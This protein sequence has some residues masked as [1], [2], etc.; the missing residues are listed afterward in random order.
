MAPDPD[1]ATHRGTGQEAYGVGSLRH[2]VL[3]SPSG[4]L[5][6]CRVGSGEDTGDP[7]RTTPAGT[8][9]FFFVRSEIVGGGPTI[10]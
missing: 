9:N 2:P 10:D 1:D 5:R 4:E 7:M 8:A 3:L 6:L